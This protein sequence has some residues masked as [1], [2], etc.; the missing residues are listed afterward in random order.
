MGAP[1]YLPSYPYPPPDPRPLLDRLMAQ[2]AAYDPR[3]WGTRP[4]VLP[5]AA[6]LVLIAL[7]QVVGHLIRPHTFGGALALTIVLNAVLYGALIAVIRR[8]GRDLARRY[9]G[10]GWAFGLQRPHWIDGAWV[11]AG[12]GLTLL[13]RLVVGVIANAATDGRAV[14]Q[15]QNLGVHTSSV[16]VY[17]VLGIIVVLIAPL[18]EETVFRGLLLRTFMRRLGFWP[19]A[20]LSSAIFAVFHTYEVRTLAGA[21]T[22]AAIVFVL[23]LV[24]CLLVRWSG[25][26]AAGM[27]VHALFNGLALLV[28]ILTD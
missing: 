17:V 11:A 6:F 7:G 19:A 28:L 3:P 15:A 18:I 13:G 10:W 21:I 26:L 12:F 8:A 1:V 14:Q 25:R 4:V 2:M 9:A 24:N 23:G 5:C 27:I 16:T 22:L 20:L